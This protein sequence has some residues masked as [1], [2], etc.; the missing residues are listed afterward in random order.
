M[1]RHA[2]H[3]P[4]P[5]PDG[6]PAGRSPLHADLF[7][8]EPGSAAA[9]AL[10]RRTSAVFEKLVAPHRAALQAYVLRLTDGDEAAADSVVKETLYR[11]AQDPGRYPQN[12][13][14]VRP[15]LVLTART[16]MRDA[17]AV[18]G[19]PAVRRSTTI[20]QALEELPDFDRD[21]LVELIYRGVSLEDAAAERGVAVATVRARLDFALQAL[22]EALDRR[23]ADDGSAADPPRP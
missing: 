21:M 14:A 11:A 4:A 20:R 12:E 9:L 17:P 3:R 22:R 5:D 2:T 16:A 19:R 6:A 7:V 18:A 13:S 1:G 8:P 10:G 15:W 23:L